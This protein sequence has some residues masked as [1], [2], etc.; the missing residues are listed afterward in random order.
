MVNAPLPDTT[1]MRVIRIT[2]MEVL[3]L[4]WKRCSER[5]EVEGGVGALHTG[6]RQ[7]IS[8]PLSWE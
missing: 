4:C 8:Y 3:E 6:M 2:G 1:P 5:A 7:G